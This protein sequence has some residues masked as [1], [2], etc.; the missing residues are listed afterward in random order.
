MFHTYMESPL[1]DLT[2]RTNGSSLTGLY[3]N[4][5][6]DMPWLSASIRDDSAQ[7]FAQAVDQL[8]EYFHGN[9]VNFDLP[10]LMLGTDF[11]L[12]VWHQLC[13]IPYGT[14]ISYAELALRVGNL[15]A[16]RAVGSANGRNPI[17][18]I[19]PCHRVIGADGTLTGYGGGLPA[20]K[21]LLDHEIKSR[22]QGAS[23]EMALAGMVS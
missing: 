10:L 13:G 14:T 15:K 19:V 3:M 21:W 4:S 16:S 7:P 23:N 9:L 8:M 11:Q 2:L 12:R 20:K 22:M 5:N 6:H 1:G 18:I 17:S